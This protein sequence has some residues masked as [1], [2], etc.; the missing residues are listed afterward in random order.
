MQ[1]F[2]EESGRYAMDS[3]RGFESSVLLG[4]IVP[5]RCVREIE[6]FAS[7]LRARLG[8][9]EL[10]SSRLRPSAIVEVC[11]F[12]AS[13]PIAAVAFVT[14]SVM[15]SQRWVGVGRARQI[16]QIEGGLSRYRRG[17]AAADP[18]RVAEAQALIQ[19]LRSEI[20]DVE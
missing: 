7:A 13:Q 19:A 11:E 6:S 14:D 17:S 4:L 1:I 15:M 18:S 2:V 20:S 8:K 12:I 3:R 5:D 9:A 10:K 16:A